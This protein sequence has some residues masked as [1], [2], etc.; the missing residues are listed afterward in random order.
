M[1][2]VQ[3]IGRRAL[4]AELGITERVL[5]A[6]V[7][8]LRQQGLIVAAP[9]GMSL[10]EEGQALLEELEEFVATIEGRTELSRTLSRTLGIPTVHVVSGDSDQHAWVKSTLGLQAATVLLGALQP[11]DV[12]AVAGGTTMAAVASMAPSKRQPFPVKVV[13]A[14]GGLGEEVEIQANTIASVLAE[15]IGGTSMMLHVPD[16]LREDTLEQL[17]ADPYV[18]QRIP[19]IRNASIVI[20]SIGDAL[21][22]AERRQLDPEEVALLRHH[23]AV[24]EAF[25][26]YFN[27][28]G[29]TVYAMTTV[30]LQLSDLER[31]RLI[32][33]VAGGHS[34]ARAIV[35]AA[36]AYRMDVLV[37]DEGAAREI[38]N[39][40]LEG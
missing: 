21:R 8:F 32:L 29:E 40:E 14:R 10:S 31:M 20:H 5:R 34:K 36:K 18:Q 11:S 2:L 27:E 23:G 25:G 17:L 37:T 22:M 15:R 6:E 4:A 3:P 9:A 12:I 35:A 16:R 30:G 7:D 26:Y 13:P 24:A 39:H 38:L 28:A 19:E 33:T 1:Y